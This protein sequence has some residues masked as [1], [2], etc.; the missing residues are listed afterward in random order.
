[1]GGPGDAPTA[2][3]DDAAL[4]RVIVTRRHKPKAPKPQSQKAPKPLEFI[5][6]LNRRAPKYKKSINESV[7]KGKNSGK[8]RF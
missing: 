3:Y 4:C 6:S 1:M 2:R 5:P 8:Y 7:N